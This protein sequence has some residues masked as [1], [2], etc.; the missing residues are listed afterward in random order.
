KG[1]PLLIE[2]WKALALKGSELWLVGPIGERER[3]LIPEL[4][5]L[6]VKGKYPF[7]ELP[8]LMR[9]CDVLVF[10]SYCDGFALVLLEAL[11]SGMPII[12]TEATAAPDLIEDGVE[13]FLIQSGDLDALRQA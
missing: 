1:I 4:P 8:D 10:P 11:A 3:K 6:C 13:G 12:S 5:G 9:Q 2:A 7:E